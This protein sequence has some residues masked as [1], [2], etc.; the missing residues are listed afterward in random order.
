MG[1]DWVSLVG[2]HELVEVDDGDVFWGGFEVSISFFEL[3]LLDIIAMA[4][5]EGFGQVWHVFDV[6]GMSRG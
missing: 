4:S 6:D 1:G 2:L 3:D 5:E